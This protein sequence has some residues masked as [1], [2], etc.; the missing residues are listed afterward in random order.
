MRKEKDIMKK[1]IASLCCISVVLAL[2]GEGW[3]ATKKHR[4]HRKS[5]VTE[6]AS[7]T[8][9][10][11]AA[12]APEPP[13][14]GWGDKFEV[15]WK[16]GLFFKSKDEKFSMKFRIRMQPRFQW[17]TQNAAGQPN[18]ET[19]QI[20]RLKL[21]WEGNAFTKNLDYKVQ[22]NVVAV[23][24]IQDMIEYVFV[25]YRFFDPLRVEFGQFKVPYDRQE[26]TSSG[27]QEFVDR[28]LAAEAFRFNAVDS[29]TTTTC[30]IPGGATITGSGITCGGGATAT[31]NTTFSQRAFQFDPGLMIHGEA[32]NKKMEYYA[33]VTNG[34]GPTRINVNKFPLVTGRVV[35]NILGQYGY[36]E[37]DVDYSE[38]PA[39]VVGAAGG[40]NS[41]GASNTNY[42]QAGGELGF[43]YKGFA[44]QSEYYFRNNRI[45]TNAA[46][47][48]NI[49]GLLPGNSNDH[50]YY[51]QAG[52]FV[53]PHHFEIA[54][55]SSQIFLA[56]PNN[57][58]SEFMGALGYYIFGHDL[59]LQ[60][61]YAFLPTQVDPA[62]NGGKGTANDQ[63]FR[64][65][66]QA[67]F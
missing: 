57:N 8:P 12:P 17:N 41:Q 10:P 25:D 49:K 51:A 36:S 43:K 27:R 24:P 3:S 29:S 35:G 59:K 4:S 45:G 16:K 46:G 64:L 47:A 60:A 40:Y 9:A 62:K 14:E 66:L 18:Q 28:S 55:R 30:T 54:A 1:I 19:F 7:T 50:G 65:Q 11:Q 34:S 61:D 22:L 15:G 23:N 44:F 67:W 52:Y 21:S 5:A 32:F 42:A 33:S 38:H 13:K 2:S 53:I 58:K 48:P 26:I 37:S 63:R 20:R 31:S 56:G 6:P 39:L